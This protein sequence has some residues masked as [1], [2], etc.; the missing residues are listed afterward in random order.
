MI[1]GGNGIMPQKIVEQKG[2][3]RMDDSDMLNTICNTLITKHAD[4]VNSSETIKFKRVKKK[5]TV[6]T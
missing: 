5:R 2:W 4:Q 3:A 1:E 6:I